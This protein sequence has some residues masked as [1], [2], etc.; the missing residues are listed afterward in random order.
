MDAE[1][2]CPS[3]EETIGPSILHLHDW[4][5]YT[6]PQTHGSTSHSSANSSRT[7]APAHHHMPPPP[8]NT[9]AREQLVVNLRLAL[10]KLCHSVL[11]MANYDRC[12]SMLV[13][14]ILR[15]ASR[16]L[17]LMSNDSCSRNSGA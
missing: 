3:V 9:P 8:L 5:L 2:M 1:S 10:G 13:I 11:L 4:A 16:M 6:Q 12:P 17:P 7:G 15:A 14:C